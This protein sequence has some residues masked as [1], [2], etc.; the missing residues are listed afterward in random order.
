MIRELDTRQTI[1]PSAFA[2][3]VLR[4]RDIDQSVAWYGAVLG[5]EVVFGSPFVCFMTYDDEHH[6][7]ALIKTPVAELAPPGAAGL[8]HLA[9]TL[10]DLGELL[11]TWKRLAGAGIEPAWC[12]NHGPTTSLYYADPDGNRIEF[13]VDNFASE[14][15]LKRWFETDT[16][17]KNPIGV[18]FDVQKLALRYEQGDPIEELLQQGAA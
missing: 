5:M 8:D 17:A 9:Y 4:V 2:H 10:R 15:E 12:I 16:F 13:Q 14:A 3:A 6:R 1:L 7:L 11:S 18:E